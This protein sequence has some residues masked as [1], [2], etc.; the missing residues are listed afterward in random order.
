VSMSECVCVRV[1]VRVRVCVCVCVLVP[2]VC[3]K[4]QDTP[5]SRIQDGMNKC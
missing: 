2:H 3:V 5:D 1:R 4:R